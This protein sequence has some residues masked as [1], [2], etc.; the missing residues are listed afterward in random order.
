MPS[1]VQFAPLLC[2]VGAVIPPACLFAEQAALPPRGGLI[3]DF[4]SDTYGEWRI[5]GDAFG[6]GP[7]RGTLLGQ[8]EVTGF[9]GGRLVNSFTGGDAATGMLSSPPFEV[10][11]DFLHMLIGGGGHAGQTCVNLLV[12]GRV[13][14]TATGPNQAPGGSEE[15]VRVYWDVTPLRGKAAVIQIV[16]R[17]AGG[18]GHINVDDIRLS[19]QPAGVPADKLDGTTHFRTFASYADAGYDQPLRPQFHF[20]SRKNW[21][22]DPNGMVYLDGEYHLFFQHNPLGNEWGN[23]T[24]GHAVSPDMVHWRQLPHALLPYGGGT[25]YSGT[26]VVDHQDVLGVRTGQTP[27][28]IAAFTHAREPFTQ[29][30]AYSTDRGRTFELVNGG[31]PV[32]GNQGYDPGERDPKVFFH[33]PSGQWVMVLWVKQGKPG[34][35]LIFNSPD[36]RNWTEVGRFDRDWVF[37]CMD[38]VHLPVD[39]DPDNKKWVIYDAS[40]EYEVGSFDGKQ[41]RSET[42]ALRG[43]HGPNY[44]AAQTFNNSPDG[45][46]VIIGWM[47]GGEE[48]PFVRAGMPF[49]MQMSF[50]STLE[51]RTTGEG[52]RLYRWPVVEIEELYAESVAIGESSVQTANASL[53]DF[54]GE[55]LDVQVEFNAGAATQLTVEVRGQQIEYRDGA[56]HYAGA[57]LPAPPVDGVAALRVLVDRASVELFANHGAAVSTHYADLSKQGRGVRLSAPQATTLRSLEVHRLRSAWGE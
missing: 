43:E 9:Q 40:F 50:P 33:Q 38:L 51:L 1:R 49:N 41:F 22:N 42:D 27:T 8:M 35:V 12:D 55:L 54:S 16:D 47:R 11:S 23:M 20:T 18:W 24:W 48:V 13:V 53:A 37:E 44:Y 32:V 56:F 28:L 39:G 36:L 14:R 17:H 21:I 26:A 5:E 4:E 34:R 45:R 57:T 25:M 6:A 7:A 15:L 46:T 52:P 31:K 30:L 10:T 2:A 19:D 3:A 29:A